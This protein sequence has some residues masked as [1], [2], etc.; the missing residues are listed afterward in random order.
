MKDRLQEAKIHVGGLARKRSW[1]PK[2]QNES[3]MHDVMFNRRVVG[4][5]SDQAGDWYE[6][7]TE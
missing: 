3:C 1:E 7:R 5:E 6:V 2:Q 4:S